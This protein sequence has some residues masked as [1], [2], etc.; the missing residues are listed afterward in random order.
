MS[1]AVVAP[2]GRIERNGWIVDGPPEI[3]GDCD[4]SGS[5]FRPFPPA[6]RTPIVNVQRGPGLDR[7]ERYLVLLFLRR[8]ISYKARRSSFAQML[9]AAQLFTEVRAIIRRP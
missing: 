5:Y 2:L 8:Y 4:G 9:G 3:R 7:D 1:R 6:P